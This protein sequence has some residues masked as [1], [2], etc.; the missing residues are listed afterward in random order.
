[1]FSAI[2]KT[3]VDSTP[4]AIGALFLDYE[5]ETVALQSE[6]P[7]EIADEDLK[8]IGAHQGILLTQLRRLCE[9]SD[10]GEPRRF[11][12]DFAKVRVLSLYLMDGY[13]IV[14][15]VDPA[16]SEALAWRQMSHCRDALLAEL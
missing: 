12:L 1:M 16:A 3:L 9:K 13:Y 14:L 15:I 7:F 4:G 10:V 6:R 8:I 5:G 2:L 11:K